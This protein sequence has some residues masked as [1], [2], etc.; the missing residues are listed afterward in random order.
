MATWGEL[1]R[2]FDLP[3]GEKNPKFHEPIS[4]PWKHIEPMKSVDD[5]FTKIFAQLYLKENLDQDQSSS[6][7]P[8]LFTLSPSSSLSSDFSPKNAASSDE[9]KKL[10]RRSGSASSFSSERSSICNNDDDDIINVEDSI[11]NE[12]INDSSCQ[13]QEEN[14]NHHDH[15]RTEYHCL[16]KSSSCKR[17]S[18]NYNNINN[19]YGGFPPPISCIGRSGKPWVSFQTIRTNGRFIL[20]EVRI[21]TQEFMH[22][23]RENG[24]LK[25]HF[26][27]SESEEEEEEEEMG[28]GDDDGGD[29]EAMEA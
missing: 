24:R 14:H 17:R 13:H 3:L 8:S 21:P 11:K 4:S 29:S 27:H 16:K 10:H 23:C 9:E 20:T 26:I 28:G 6:P 7:S 15:A 25:L 5:H 22:A 1:E 12:S 2:I 19:N 18:N